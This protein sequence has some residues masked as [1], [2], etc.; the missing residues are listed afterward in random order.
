MTPPTES[1]GP[2][3]RRLSAIVF[4][5]VAGYSA[6]TQRDETG[7]LALVRDDFARMEQ[8]AALLG[9][10]VL[11]TMGDGMLI[12]FS[13]AVEAATFAL[14][15]QAE[16]A[17]RRAMNPPERALVHRMGI[18]VGDVFRQGGR[19][20][21]DGVNIAA[22]LQTLAPVGGICASQTVYD[23]IRGK[24]AVEAEPLGE[25][26]LKGISEKLAVYSLL[27]PGSE[28]RA[29]FKG[30]RRAGLAAAI[31]A[32]VAVAATLALFLDRNPQPQHPPQAAVPS[33]TPAAALAVPVTNEK[34]IA[35]L[36]FTNMTEDKDSGYF[37][38]GVH[39]DL[40][41]H[42]AKISDLKV[43]SRTS[44][45]QYRNTQK[46]IGQIARELGVAFVLEG[47]VRRAGNHVRV[48]GQLIRASTDAHVWAQAY[49]GDLTDI[50]ALQAQ[51]ATQ[52][53]GELKATLTHQETTLVV[54]APSVNAEAYALYLKARSL[55]A[56][57]TYT[58]SGDSGSIRPL[59]Q[60]ALAL[61]PRFVAAWAEL[62]HTEISDYFS[63]NGD[64]A[65]LL[66]SAKAA[67]DHIQEL[68][69][70]SA[71]LHQALG[72]YYLFCLFDFTNAALHIERRLALEPGSAE[73]IYALGLIERRQGHWK[74]SVELFRRARELDPRNEELT[75]ILLDTLQ[76]GHHD[77]EAQV[78]RVELAAQFPDSRYY[79]FEKMAY[80]SLITG[81]PAPVEAWFASFP[82]AVR[83]SDEVVGIEMN[84]AWYH[85]QCDRYLKL[86]NEHKSES[87]DPPPI[88]LAAV[89]IEA[90]HRDQAR[91][92]L[93]ANRKQLQADIEHFPD[94]FESFA[95]LGTTL[96]ML[97]ET[98]DALAAADRAVALMPESVDHLN[99][100][101]PAEKRVMTWAWSG[102]KKEAIEEIARRLHLYG[103]FDVFTLA[104]WP[105]W[106]PIRNDPALQ[107]LLK[108]PANRTT[109]F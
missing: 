61:D 3:E 106:L 28:T 86:Y 13:S 63:K 89:L 80:E 22:R 39:E 1:T 17:Y 71:E 62:A 23:L 66:Q 104:H 101:D 65:A 98:K 34:S 88:I 77:D 97:G 26:E 78:I 6:R 32:A 85:G 54:A 8:E 51:L 14:K 20:S 100:I 83:N 94:D 60:K 90:G 95:E 37:A 75:R 91:T 72:E 38:D 11:N 82:P 69:P 57:S 29:P 19:V 68:A 55:R 12:A 16:F 42:L 31:A 46:P 96:A 87:I 73:A 40:L 107:A 2:V 7:T 45:M 76:C 4:S 59:L 74:R 36:P 84:W 103:R 93:E 102:R 52:I 58:D 64:P 43:I 27:L 24:I 5:D 67:I 53:A 10:E 79:T 33:P 9:G 49:D 105:Q 48:T 18:H 92:V 56:G 81:D 30:S 41:T 109:R 35:V 21:G 99:G 44:V 15:L 108:D 47:S 70:D 50:F 25:K